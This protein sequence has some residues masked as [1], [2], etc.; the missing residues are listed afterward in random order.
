M[1]IFYLTVL[2]LILSFLVDAG[3][4]KIT[5][6]ICNS[7]TGE[8]IA[9]ASIAFVEIQKGTSSLENGE[10]N[11]E[12]DSNEIKNTLFISC[13]N[14]QSTTISIKDF[15]NYSTKKI[16][17]EPATYQMA[18]VKVTPKESIELIINK[19]KKSKIR[20]FMGNTGF[21]FIYARYFEYNEELQY[22]SSIHIYCESHFGN[23]KSKVRLRIYEP[24]TLSNL[25]SKD[26]VNKEI[27]VVLKSEKI[28]EID[29]KEYNIRVPKNGIYIG[30]EYLI[31][32]ENK[33]TYTLIDFNGKDKKVIGYGPSLGLNSTQTTKTYEYHAGIW[34]KYDIQKN[35]LPKFKE[36]VFYDA[37]I[38][39][40][41]TN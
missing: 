29:V 40:T 37:A 36:N 34:R 7:K 10:F 31:I 9:Y 20:C 18:E 11:V 8:P 23:K 35:P 1:K 6:T 2:F 15:L 25:P 24:D 14:F 39:I 19:L 27:I 28:N 5:G 38:S 22:L 16:L 32:P 26:L 12:I 33:Y 41:V 21:P 17:L 13:L 30:V 3:S 4:I